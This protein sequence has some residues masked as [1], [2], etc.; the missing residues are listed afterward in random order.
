MKQLK[1]LNRDEALSLLPDDI[2]HE[3]TAEDE[4][5]FA[6]VVSTRLDAD[7]IARVVHP[8]DVYLKER[9]VLA[10]H[11]HPEFVPMDLIMQRV[12]AMFPGRTSDL[13]IPTQHNDIMGCDNSDYK[14]VEV[15]CYARAFNQ[16]VQLLI[17]GRNEVMDRADV[18]RS[19][20]AYTFKYRAS[21]LFDFIHTITGPDEDRL[22]QASR[23]TGADRKLIDFVQAYVKK[24]R[25][26]LER[27][28]DDL[29]PDV[30][31]NKLLR[32]F[33]DSLRP[34]Y[35]HGLINRAQAF[36]TAVKQI[37]K[38][39]F[40]AQYFYRT[41]EI[42]EEARAIGACIVIPHPEQF[43]P[44]LL[45][46]YDIDGIEVWNP[47]SQ[48]Y[49]EF[50]IEVIDKMNNRI[51]MSQRPILVFMGDDTHMGEK[52]KDPAV[53][54]SKKAGR[55]IGLQ[56]AWTDYRINKKLIITKMHKDGVIAEYKARLAG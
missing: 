3:I 50:L 5:R 46:D 38:Q 36:L 48:Q 15:D 49:T 30:V 16:K 53:Q 54:D 9:S 52:V 27:D 20:I 35:G 11:W 23:A 51:G 56:P 10:V 40:P 26:I 2:P 4:Q 43:W 32:N 21:Q 29:P 6:E 31:K 44:V 25:Y 45:A 47:Q 13:I 33:F 8:E 22:E 24:I 14:G 55:E 18:L 42:I 12:D 39:H 7:Q 1:S 41:S 28:L 17:H 34:V 19:M 37:V